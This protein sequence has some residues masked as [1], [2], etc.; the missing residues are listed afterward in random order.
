VA[1]TVGHDYFKIPE[2][3][4][5]YR[6]AVEEMRERDPLVAMKS[7]LELV[8]ALH[9]EEQGHSPDETLR[10]QEEKATETL[11]MSLHALVQSNEDPGQ[12]LD[13]LWRLRKES[14]AAEENGP[15]M[16]SLQKA[17]SVRP[18]KV[19]Q[20]LAHGQELWRGL[21]THEAID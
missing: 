16:R 19:L 12:Y 15:Y 3:V 10:K 6:A 11:K 9:I 18:E 8:D 13:E 21:L 2:T 4:E 7:S 17:I 1:K 14:W 5:A 20:E